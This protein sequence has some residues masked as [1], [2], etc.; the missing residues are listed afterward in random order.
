MVKLSGQFNWF[1]Q[2]RLFGH[3]YHKSSSEAVAQ[4]RFDLYRSARRRFSRRFINQGPLPMNFTRK[5]SKTEYLVL[6]T[7]GLLIFLLIWSALTYHAFI[8]PLFLPSPVAVLR[9]LHTL[10]AS[11]DLWGNT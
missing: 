3:E 11:G 1:N 2:W 5:I 6:A 4:I 10:A 7:S 8:K 9:S